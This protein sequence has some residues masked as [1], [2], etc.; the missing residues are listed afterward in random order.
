MFDIVRGRA[1]PTAVVGMRDVDAWDVRE[2]LRRSY[3]EAFDR[4]T[5]AGNGDTPW[6]HTAYPPFTTLNWNL[7]Q[8]ADLA[9]CIIRDIE[10]GQTFEKPV[11]R[12]VP[13]RLVAR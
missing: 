5:F 7:D 10:A 8:I 11:V 4:L 9:S 1:A 2:I 13:P 3:P 12:L 6:S